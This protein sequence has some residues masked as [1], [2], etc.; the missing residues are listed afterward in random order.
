MASTRYFAQTMPGVEEI[1]W[2]EIKQKLPTA[3]FVGYQFAKEQNGIVLFDYAGAVDDVLNLSTA[4]DL[5]MVAAAINKVSRSRRD[6]RIITETVQKGEAFG[7]AAKALM[8]YRQFSQPPTYTVFPRKIGK[9]DYKQSEMATA[10]LKGIERRLP[11][12]TGVSTYAQVE[13][14]ANLLG[15]SLLIG[16]RL[17]APVK[18]NRKLPKGGIKDSTAA[19]L[20]LL[21]EPS[22]QDLF[23]DPVCGI[24]QTLKARRQAGPYQ[25]LLG[26]DDRGV[27][28]AQQQ[29]MPRRGGRG[30]TIA[31]REWDPGNLP[32]ADQRVTKV[33]TYIPTDNKPFIAGVLAELE[34]VV[35]ENGRII[36]FTH[37]Y[38]Q[39]KTLLRDYPHLEVQTG[40]SVMDA[41][42][43]GRIYI[44]KRTA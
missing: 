11:R 7:Q 28:V 37:A 30:R 29:V 12:W 35:V 40:Y 39:L 14:W 9:H 13:I 44:I 22:P 26:G 6:L 25:Q 10:V 18:Q 41:G 1:T 2:L 32:I 24:G 4:E 19:A 20:V 3:T 43:W 34:R 27:D 42:H 5:F 31:I 15:S 36:I 8:R 23:L 21:T 33:A 17:N 16:F 38:D